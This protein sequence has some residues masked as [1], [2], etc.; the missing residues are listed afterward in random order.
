MK[1]AL[2]KTACQSA[3]P[4]WRSTS[5]K[6]V[7][8]ASC[9]CLVAVAAAMFGCGSSSSPTTAACT[10]GPYN[11][12]GDWTL[13]TPSASGPGVIN[14]SGLAVFFQ[15]N[16]NIPAP[17]DTAV[18]PSISGAC[19][20]SGTATAYGTQASGGDSASNTVSGTVSSSTSISGT[21]SD[22]SSGAANF[23]ITSISPLSGPVTALSGNQWLGEFEGLT[24]PVI[25]NI[26]FSSTGSGSSMSFNGF[27]TAPDGST[28]N[29][30]GTFT[31]EG[32]SGTDLNVF[33]ISV[34]SLDGGCPLGATVTGVGFESSS[35]YFNLNGNATGTY[36][37]AIPSNSAA[38]FEIFHQTP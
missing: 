17:G 4:N 6:L 31:Q 19:S 22:T 13:T 33:D 37:Y 5:H 38:V 12:V 23:S 15:T 32:G 10:G 26:V 25:W 7:L 16:T 8:C 11:V 34:A 2:S 20:F 28:C 21:I 18:F 9:V 30:S 36:F 35:D 3:E 14:S 24:V 27:G 29:M 1:F